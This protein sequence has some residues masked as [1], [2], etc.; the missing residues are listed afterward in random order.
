MKL[1]EKFN[2][3]FLYR[4]FLKDK[5]FSSAVL[6]N[7]LS[8]KSYHTLMSNF[9]LLQVPSEHKS[10]VGIFL[11]STFTLFITVIILI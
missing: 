10:N 11:L 3:L 7:N 1:G 6:S 5:S 4:C 9:V 8:S 2:E